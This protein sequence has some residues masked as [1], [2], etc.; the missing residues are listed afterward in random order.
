[1]KNATYFWTS[2][3]VQLLRFCASNARKLKSH[4]LCG[5]AKK[6]NKCYLFLSGL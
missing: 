1:M 6:G 5:M 3:M 2:L 4:M